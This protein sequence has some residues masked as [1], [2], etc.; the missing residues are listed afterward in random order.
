MGWPE[1][2]QGSGSSDF[3]KLDAGQTVKLHV[4]SE[5]PHS[6][7]S[8]FFQSIKRS[9]VCPGEDC[10]CCATQDKETGKRMQHSF[11]VRDSEGN[12]KVWTMGNRVAETIKN[13]FDTYGGL[14][15]VDLVVKR[16]G[17]DKNTKYGITPVPTK[18]D[19]SDVDVSTLTPLEE[20]NA[21]A[22]A[23]VIE[24]MMAGVDPG[25]E[26]D[27]SKLEQAAE[28]PA[29]E[30]AAA[31]EE[32]AAEEEAAP[33][34]VKKPAPKP[35]AKPAARPA[36]PASNGA[37]RTVVV[38]EIMTLLAK[39]AKYKTLQARGLL[40]KKCAPGK[41]AVASMTLPELIK[42]RNELKKG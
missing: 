36:V 30:E 12:T 9:A 32:E 39:S 31:T 10:P 21:P 29:T 11:Y 13:I 25:A 40:F 17:S 16:T 15:D 28:E 1:V 6:F 5:E 24:Q 37:D 22:T 34:P 38:K 3:L 19:V 20:I 27:P 2:G 42:V 7:F 23:E 26:F 14:A 41:T 8:H 18:I 35:A 33:P 4:L